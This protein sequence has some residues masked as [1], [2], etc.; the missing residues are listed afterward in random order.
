MDSLRGL[1][2]PADSR[3]IFR[4]C[5]VRHLI[6]KTALS[7]R[8][9]GA[10][11]RAGRAAVRGGAGAGAGPCGGAGDAVR[12]PHRGAAERHTGTRAGGRS[13]VRVSR[14]ACVRRARADTRP[15][16]AR[17]RSPAPPGSSPATMAAP[18]ITACSGAARKLGPSSH[19]ASRHASTRTTLTLCCARSG[20]GTCIS[21]APPPAG[22]GGNITVRGRVGRCSAALTRRRVVPLP[23]V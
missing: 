19:A 21:A 13:H 9:H 5:W 15:R 22:N 4:S 14:A 17:R 12:G 23:H 6:R 1:F 20:P 7:M 16:P 11:S 2:L 8:R 10:P 3:S 18:A